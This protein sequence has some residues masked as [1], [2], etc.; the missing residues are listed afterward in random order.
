M[1]ISSPV[2][3]LRP[4]RAA[5]STTLKEPKPLTVTS[6]PLERAS[7]MAENTAFTA[8]VLAASLWE[9]ASATARTRSCFRI[10]STPLTDSEAGLLQ[11]DTHA[12]DCPHNLQLHAFSHAFGQKY[13]NMRRLGGK[14]LFSLPRCF[15]HKQASCHASIEALHTVR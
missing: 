15:K 3:G 4:W 8:F 9:V 11:P 13:H 12:G 1:V 10:V 2:C 5:R 6:S 7:S 14:R